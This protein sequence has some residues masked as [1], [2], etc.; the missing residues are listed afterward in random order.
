MMTA[1]FMLS[2]RP[3]L[4]FTAALFFL[5]K[6]SSH[7]FCIPKYIGNRY[8]NECLRQLRKLEQ[9]KGKIGSNQAAISFLKACVLYNLCSKFLRFKLG[10]L[11]LQ[12]AKQAERFRNKLLLKELNHKRTN[13]QKLFKTDRFLRLKLFV[14]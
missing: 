8:G 9:L 12:G 6:L 10:K 3:V 13:L 4:R 11:K 2:K 7:I 14:W 1:K 5:L